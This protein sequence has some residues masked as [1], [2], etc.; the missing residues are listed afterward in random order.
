MIDHYNPEIKIDTVIGEKP[1]N[2]EIEIDESSSS[3]DEIQI[4]EPNKVKVINEEVKE[5]T[6]T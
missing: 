6:V 2:F 5:I 1:D 3:G 4:N